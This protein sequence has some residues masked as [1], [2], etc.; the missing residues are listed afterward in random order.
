MAITKQAVKWSRVVFKMLHDGFESLNKNDYDLLQQ[1]LKWKIK[2]V[3][4]T[5]INNEGHLRVRG[6]SIVFDEVFNDSLSNLWEYL[7]THKKEFKYFNSQQ[8]W[9]KVNDHIGNKLYYK[10]ITKTGKD[11]DRGIVGAPNHPNRFCDI[12]G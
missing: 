4:K 6:I 9:T 11:W 5:N 12:P 1:Y 3:L 7:E 2:S 10:F 8:L